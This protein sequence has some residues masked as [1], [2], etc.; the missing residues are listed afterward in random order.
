VDADTGEIVRPKRQTFMGPNGSAPD[1]AK[2]VAELK[3]DSKWGGK[4]HGAFGR[5][6]E[7][8]DLVDARNSLNMPMSESGSPE[9][10]GGQQS[11]I[12]LLPQGAVAVDAR[13]V[14]LGSRVYRLDL[15]RPTPHTA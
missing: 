11:R 13:S 5:K 12:R 6:T 7:N 1:F 14:R 4:R 10:S 2:A 8:S 3:L 15:S 9:P